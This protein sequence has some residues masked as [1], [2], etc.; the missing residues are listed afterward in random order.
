MSGEGAGDAYNRGR[1]TLEPGLRRKSMA[2]MGTRNET[3]RET[4]MYVV[5]PALAESPKSVSHLCDLSGK[6]P[7]RWG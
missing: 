6:P 2:Q 7:R 1:R 3:T 5:Y 4:M